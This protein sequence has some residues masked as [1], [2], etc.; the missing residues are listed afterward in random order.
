MAQTVDMTW[1]RMPSGLIIISNGGVHMALTTKEVGDLR[2]IIADI[3]WDEQRYYKK[4]NR[5]GST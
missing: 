5:H 1:R 2:R 4:D 3:Q